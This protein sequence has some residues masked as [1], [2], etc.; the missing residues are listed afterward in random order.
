MAKDHKPQQNIK[1]MDSNQLFPKTG[2]GIIVLKD[3]KVLF[4]K[5]ISSHGSGCW[6]FPGGHLEFGESWE[7]CAFRETQEELDLAIEN[8]RF[9]AITN[10]IFHQ[11]QK[12]YI[13]IFLLADYVSGSLAIKEPKEFESL[14]WFDWENPPQPLFLPQQNLYKQNFNPF[15][16]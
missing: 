10:D 8:V 7:Q 14:E 4:G 16:V 12:H 15:M 1:A 3:K 5:R 13:T 2:I 11:E 6:G 9:A